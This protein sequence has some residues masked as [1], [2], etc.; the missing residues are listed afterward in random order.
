MSVLPGFAAPET[1]GWPLRF[2]QH[3]VGVDTFTAVT[4]YGPLRYR[5]YKPMD[6]QN[7]GGLVLLHGIHDLGIEEPRLTTFARA[8]PGAGLAI[9]TPQTSDPA[10]YR[11]TPP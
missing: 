11:V 7:P 4:P 8:L 3:P 6:V 10:G 5:I 2:A 1:T 9:K